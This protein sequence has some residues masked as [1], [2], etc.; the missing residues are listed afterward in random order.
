MKRPPSGEEPFLVAALFHQ[1]SGDPNLSDGAHMPPRTV[2]PRG[3]MRASGLAS[4]SICPLLWSAAFQSILSTRAPIPLQ[5]T[6]DCSWDKVL[7]SLAENIA[8]RRR[9]PIH[10]M[11]LTVTALPHAWYLAE[12][13][14]SGFSAYLGR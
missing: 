6:A 10:S 11:T 8:A 14:L 5:A 3:H 9:S 7:S 1:Q 2:S 13:S 12:S 4:L